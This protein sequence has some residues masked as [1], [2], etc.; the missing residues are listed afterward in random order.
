MSVEPTKEYIE[1]LTCHPCFFIALVEKSKLF[2]C[3][4]LKTTRLFSMS[5]EHWYKSI[6]PIGITASGKSK[7]IAFGEFLQNFKFNPRFNHKFMDLNLKFC[8]NSRNFAN[9]PNAIVFDLPDEVKAIV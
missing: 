4:F 8:R 5:N 2:S 7:T 9:S 6:R 1:K 3:F